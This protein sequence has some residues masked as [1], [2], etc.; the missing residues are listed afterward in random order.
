MGRRGALRPC[1][2]DGRK[3]TATAP[4][5]CNDGLCPPSIFPI[6]CGSGCPEGSTCISTGGIFPATCRR[7]CV[8]DAE[9]GSSTTA[10]LSLLGLAE[11]GE[12]AVVTCVQPD[13]WA[14]PRRS[15]TTTRWS[16]WRCSRPPR[17]SPVAEELSEPPRVCRRLCTGR[18]SGLP[19]TAGASRLRPGP[20]PAPGRPPQSPSTRR[21]ARS[22]RFCA[23]FDISCLPAQLAVQPG[24]LEERR[25]ARRRGLQGPQGRLRG[26]A[27]RDR[28]PHL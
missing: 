12:N 18:R 8:T 6:P 22:H 7:V 19:T 5:I 23:A 14:S 21:G 16:A 25:A 20:P 4:R 9:C 26:P 28:A 27:E 11:A 15:T 17:S 3:L 13:S 10:T 1:R 2:G 24:G